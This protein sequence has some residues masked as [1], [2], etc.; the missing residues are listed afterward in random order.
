M[1]SQRNFDPAGGEWS[2]M[3]RWSSSRRVCHSEPK[4]HCRSPVRGG[5]VRLPSGTPTL[6][7]G[8]GVWCAAGRLVEGFA[9]PS[10]SLTA[11][12]RCEAEAYA[13]PARPRF[14]PKKL[15]SSTS[16]IVPRDL[17]L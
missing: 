8:S 5:G 17:V 9:T 12:R 4:S 7:A 6:R 3:C 1:P 16:R 15:R 11:A 13:F 14:V 10:R 2:V